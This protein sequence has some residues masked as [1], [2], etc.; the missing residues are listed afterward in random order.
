MKY[1]IRP[2]TIHLKGNDY[3]EGTSIEQEMKVATQTKQMPDINKQQIFYTRRQDGVLPE[4]DIRTDRW[5]FAQ[6]AQQHVNEE[7]H[8]KIKERIEQSQVTDETSNKEA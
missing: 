1:K 7:F 5:E 3:F 4:T 2:K 6:N 8:K